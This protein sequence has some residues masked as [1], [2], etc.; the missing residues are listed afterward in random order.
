MFNSAVS[1][2][3]DPLQDACMLPQ[4]AESFEFFSAWPIISL[5]QFHSGYDQIM[6]Q[7]DSQD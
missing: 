4:I 6:L 2:H 5:I 7:E 3:Q 1:T